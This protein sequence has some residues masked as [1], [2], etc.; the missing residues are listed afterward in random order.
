[1]K[2][3]S[4]MVFAAAALT[5]L[6]TQR[7]MRHRVLL[8]T[9]LIV[10]AIA[11]P[12]KFDSSKRGAVVSGIDLSDPASAKDAFKQIADQLGPVHALMNVAGAF[13]WNKVV[14]AIRS[15][16]A[17]DPYGRVYYTDGEYPKVTHAQIATGGSSKPTAWY[18]LGIPAPGVPVGI[19]AI[20]PPVGGVDDDLTDVLRKRQAH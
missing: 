13:A 2:R 18:R 3:Y 10:F 20:I 17:Q 1:M 9:T 12:L 15:P 5:V 7:A 16:I 19:G 14:E 4:G 8:A 6:R 11:S